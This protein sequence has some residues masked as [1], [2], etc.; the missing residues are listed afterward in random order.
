MA[1]QVRSRR[2]FAVLVAA[3][4]CAQ[5]AVAVP[6]TVAQVRDRGSRD[7]TAVLAGVVRAGDEQGPPVRRAL[8]RLGG[9][10]VPSGAIATTD[11]EGRFAFLRLPAGRYTVSVS[12]PAWVTTFLGAARPG[13]APGRFFALDADEQRTDLVVPL[14]RGAVISGR[15]VDPDG[16]P[17]AG[18]SPSVQ[19]ARM[20]GGRRVL[21]RMGSLSS[22][23]DDSGEFRVYGLAPG[24]YI[25]G[26]SPP[27]NGPNAGGRLTTGEE[28]SWAT[29]R[30]GSASGPP[31]A[32][33]PPGPAVIFAPV[34][35]PGTLEADA[36]TPL[37]VGPGEERSGVDLTMRYV[38]T[39]RVTGTVLWPDGAT[40]RRARVALTS[41]ENGPTG[42]S[43][44]NTFSNADERGQFEFTAV[45]PGQYVLTVR[46]SS[47]EPPP[48]GRPPGP[49]PPQAELDLWAATDLT[50]N[51]FDIEGVVLTL[52]PGLTVTGTVRL[53][54]QDP[55]APITPGLLV[56]MVSP[57]AEPSPA[58][59]QFN[60][61]AKA[62]GSFSLSG[63][64]PGR[65]VLTARPLGP[66]VTRSVV[67]SGREV[68]DESFEIP[69]GQNVDATITMTSR[70]S[71]LNGTI[72]DASGRPDPNY[73]VFLFSADPT[74]WRAGSVRLRQPIRPDE[75]GVYRYRNVQPGDYFLI[76]LTDAS[77]VD[78]LDPAFLAQAAE[79]AIRVTI[80]DGE[81]KVIDVK[82]AGG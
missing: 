68:F 65:Y 40:G 39:G 72:Y 25:V 57:P 2:S 77:E 67:V 53:E 11:D 5:M 31:G 76:A 10:G 69:P 8:V 82:L 79:G 15:I 13:V 37:T 32:A 19:I 49:P 34:Y 41:E 14:I 70:V 45:P 55:D 21:S 28:V 51:G 38:P 27:G 44:T 35:Y 59:S 63:V 60:T 9:T 80:A 26:V 36:A 43:I 56:Q 42:R 73:F 46:G 75:H 29:R 54:G 48:P 62:D 7:G 78:W 6:P 61:P 50:L 12:K 47:G 20:A 30:A 33:P 58:A 17:L 16:R 22:P 4:L 52:Q 66:W 24:T 81:Q 1:S 18:V 23:T 3:V 74:H 71:N 64:I